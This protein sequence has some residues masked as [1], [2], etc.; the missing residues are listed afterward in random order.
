MVTRK[1][2]KIYADGRTVKTETIRTGARSDEAPFEVRFYASKRKGEM[3][4]SGTQNCD[5][6]EFASA[7]ALW[8][9]VVARQFHADPVELSERMTQ[10]L[11]RVLVSHGVET[12]GA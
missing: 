3:F 12:E 7:L 1:A 8:I 2:I 10:A 11:L 4:I 6:T 9:I 5:V